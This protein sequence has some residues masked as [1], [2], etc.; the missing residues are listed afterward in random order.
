MAS[1]ESKKWIKARNDE[2]DSL[3]RNKTWIL[4]KRT[5]FM[6]LVSC[7]WLYKKKVESVGT[8]SIRYKA[9]LIARGFT[10][11]E[12]VEEGVDY[13]EVFA[14]VVKHASIRILLSVVNQRDWE[15]QQL[16]VKTA[17]LHGD[18]EESIYMHQPEGY[19][20]KG[21]EGKLCLLKKSLYGL[22]QSPRQWNNKFDA[23][24][25]DS[26]FTRSKYD[27]CVY[28]K[29]R[30]GVPVAYPLI[31]VDDILIVGPSREE[32]QLVKDGLNRSFEM[33]DLGKC[34]EDPR[35]GYL[36]K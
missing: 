4:V 36:Q 8:E 11:E 30:N 25:S 16:D 17:F 13:N 26:G 6:K 1:S 22:K 23:H 20:K 5:D 2:I 19:V 32:V 31:Y 28:I 7:K 34:K 3:I 10:Q 35:Y 9:R 21:D 15:M 33:K 29:K 18:L 14:L 27:D 12:E 24:M